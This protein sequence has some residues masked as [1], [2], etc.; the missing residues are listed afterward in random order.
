MSAE[1]NELA[2]EEIIHLLNLSECAVFTSTQETDL[3][4]GYAN[5]RFYKMIKYSPEE[6]KEE[7]GNRVMELLEPDERQ[8]IRTLIARQSAAGGKIHLEFRIRRK[9]GVR[10]WISLIAEYCFENGKK[11]LYCSAINISKLKRNMEDLYNAKRESEVIANSIPGGMIKLRVSDYTLLYANDGFYRLSGY[12]RAEYM[13]TFGNM[14]DKVIH[15]DD[16]ERVTNTVRTAIENHGSLGVEYRIINRNG[17]IR[18][19]YANGCRVDDQDG[20]PVFLCVIMDITSRKLL[21]KRLEDHVR[22]TKCLHEYKKDEEWTYVIETGAI[23]RSGYLEN[24]YS[25]DAVIENFLE[26]EYLRSI[27]KPEDVPRFQDEF[28]QLMEKPMSMQ[29]V[30]MLKDSQGEYRLMDIK[31]ISVCSDGGEKPDRIFGET[32]IAQEPELIFNQLASTS[33]EEKVIN[34]VTQSQSKEEDTVTALISFSDFLYKME[35]KIKQERKEKRYAI[36]CCDLNEYQKLSYHYG[37]SSSNEILQSLAN[38][39]KTVIPEDNLCRVRGDYFLG[40]FTYEDSGQLLKVF[41]SLQREIDEMESGL[42]YKTYGTTTGIYMLSEDD[43]DLNQMIEKADLARRSI[44]GQKGNHY[45]VYTDDLERAQFKEEEIIQDIDNALKNHTV[46]ICYQPRMRGKKENV[47]GCKVVPRIQRRTGEYLPL[48]DMKR[49]SDRTPNM[50]KLVFYVLS[51]VCKTQGVWKE[52]GKKIMPISLDITQ[53]QLCSKGALERIDQI[54]S[55]NNI[56]PSEIIFEIQ[57]RYFRDVTPQFQTVL[58]ELNRKGY[59]IVL[60]RFASDHIAINSIRTLP[61]HGIKFHG[62][63]FQENINDKKERLIYEKM[64]E[65]VKE[66]GMKVGCGGI[67]TEFQE[68]IAKSIGCDIL[69]GDLYYGTVRSD[70]FEKCFLEN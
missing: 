61:L 16:A 63:F 31:M 9:D 44:K 21:E 33:K 52:Q 17:E 36:M 42:S 6:F 8:K 56:A 25:S 3:L 64:I 62:E 1:L 29:S 57:E 69:E 67:H 2:K 12:N 15:P 41:S 14:C 55:E 59:R 66:L 65:L 28:R 34:L 46:E 24:T 19:S 23:H 22:R 10:L 5:D 68:N 11:V 70:V 26:E 32:C 48:E 18:W 20:S 50:Q 7:C 51:Q 60:S 45:A 53:G 4:L 43:I 27:I 58:E 54:L 35:A 49:Y 47:I 30:F 39:L 40:L 38:V 13:S 37:I